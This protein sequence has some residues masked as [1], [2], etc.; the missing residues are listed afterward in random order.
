MLASALAHMHGL[1]IAHRDVKP[2][3][4]LFVD[5]DLTSIKLCAASP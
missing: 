4:V 2:E 3:N 5:T 1:G